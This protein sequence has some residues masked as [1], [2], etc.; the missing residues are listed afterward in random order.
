MKMTTIL[1]SF[2]LL[3]IVSTTVTAAPQLPGGVF[4]FPITFAPQFPDA[5]YHGPN[6]CQDVKELPVP[7]QEVQMISDPGIETISKSESCKGDDNVHVCQTRI[8]T[9]GQSTLT[10]TTYKCCVGFVHP[11]GGSYCI[12]A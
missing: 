2:I 11:N 3:G 12:Q 4:Q 9:N 8:T 1:C 7:E 6:V 10:E 5:W